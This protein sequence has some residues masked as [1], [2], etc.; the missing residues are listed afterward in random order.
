[1]QLMARCIERQ[2]ADPIPIPIT[3][4]AESQKRCATPMPNQSPFPTFSQKYFNLGNGN[5]P[6][7]CDDRVRNNHPIN[8]CRNLIPQV[9]TPLS[10]P[11]ADRVPDYEA[12]VPSCSYSD[13]TVTVDSISNHFSGMAVSE[14]SVLVNYSDCVVCGKSAP[15]IQSEAVNDYL[16][17]TAIPGETLAERQTKSRAFLGG[18]SAGTFLLMP[19][20]LSQAA[21]CE[22]NW[23]SIA[24]SHYSTLP[25]LRR[26]D[27]LSKRTEIKL[28]NLFFSHSYITLLLLNMELKTGH[29]DMFSHILVQIYFVF[30]CYTVNL[31]HDACKINSMLV[32]IGHQGVQVAETRSNISSPVAVDSQSALILNQS[33]C[34]INRS[35]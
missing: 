9:D 17:E 20:V 26:I 15:Q 18:M 10:P 21:A 35:V 2:L 27:R 8:V 25:G 30:G 5:D 6:I 24:Y 16:S 32:V 29:G 1:M 14:A 19:G 31:I 33:R 11:V 23:Y 34:S 4:A 22:R 3:G 13:E 28:I 7:S 12:S